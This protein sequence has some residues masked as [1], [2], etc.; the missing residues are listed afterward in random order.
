VN[1]KPKRPKSILIATIIAG[2]IVFGSF[3]LVLS[4]KHADV[5]VRRPYI[6]GLKDPLYIGRFVLAWICFPAL[7]IKPKTKATYYL[8]A[9][10]LAVLTLAFLRGAIASGAI[11]VSGVKLARWIVGW[12]LAL[13][14][15]LLFYRFSFCRPSREYFGFVSPTNSSKENG[16]G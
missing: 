15:A 2:L 12:L 11:P 9:A 16:S 14:M 5:D 13:L 8:S 6:E 4:L 1:V 10:L 3:L 7:V